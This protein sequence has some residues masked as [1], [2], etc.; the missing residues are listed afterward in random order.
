MA[1]M[2][3]TA[4]AAAADVWQVPIGPAASAGGEAAA[5]EAR[6]LWVPLGNADRS[7]LFGILSLCASRTSVRRPPVRL[8]AVGELTFVRSHSRVRTPLSHARAA[9]ACHVQMQLL[10]HFLAPYRCAHRAHGCDGPR[11]G[12]K[13]SESTQPACCA[14][15][16]ERRRHWRARPVIAMCKCG[17]FDTSW[18]IICVC[19]AH[20]GAAA[21][22][23]A[24]SCSRVLSGA[25]PRVRGDAAATG[26]RRRWVQCANADYSTLFDTLAVSASRIRARRPGSDCKKAARLA[27]N[28]P[29]IRRLCHNYDTL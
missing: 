28:H 12:L 13:L 29:M 20:M 4:L 2:G 10:R 9:G 6:G 18:H 26:A 27:Y 22:V 17:Q 8:Q 25:L 1:H 16:C 24:T 21:P 19:I 15:A 11:S 5:T 14:S 7:T 23:A 3:A